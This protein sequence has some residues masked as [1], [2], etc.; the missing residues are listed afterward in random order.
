M[1]CGLVD[2]AAWVRMVF[3]GRV[4]EG[5]IDSEIRISVC[6]AIKPYRCGFGVSWGSVRIFLGAFGCGSGRCVLV[7]L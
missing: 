3:E 2:E 4:G 1:L 6:S 5:F 7:G